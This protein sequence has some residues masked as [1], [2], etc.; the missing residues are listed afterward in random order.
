VTRRPVR[1]SDWAALLDAVFRADAND[2][3]TWLEWKSTLDLRSKEQMATIVA[4]AII[5]MANR[6]PDRAATTVGGIGILLIGMEPGAVHSVAQVDNADLDKL[7]SPY[8]GADGPVW[9]PHWTQYDDRQVLIIEVTPPRWGD[10]IHAFRKEFQPTRDPAAQAAGRGRTVQPITNGAIFVR[11]LAQSVPA[12]HMEIT[13]L[14]NR[15]A[16]GAQDQGIEVSVTIDSPYPL[17]RYRW[18]EDEFARFLAAEAED[19]MGPLEAGRSRRSAHRPGTDFLAKVAAMGG[20][21]P[22]VRAGLTA[23]HLAGLVETIP[24]QRSEAEYEVS[25]RD[26]LDAIRAA[27]PEAMRAAAAYF[28]R[29][30]TFILVNQSTRN[31]Q[32]VLVRL[33]VA[34]DADA[35]E[36]ESDTSGLD[37]WKL[38]PRGPRKWGPRRRELGS[39]EVPRWYTQPI[40]AYGGST[41]PSITVERGGSFTVNFLPVNL[42][43][44][45]R[46]VLADD[47]SV[48]IPAS[49]TEPV[50]ATWTATA[51]NADGPPAEGTFVLRFDGDEINILA[52]VLHAGAQDEGSEG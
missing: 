37:L 19:L 21:S 1:I 24:E 16:S 32:E 9:Q 11:K 3:Q 26:H 45:Q 47:W 18:S 34:G 28:V 46:H 43:P 12:D 14:A 35:R 4:K 17:S 8:V 13:R 42:R 38:L 40:P 6:D 31:Y 44:Q 20:V 29:P 50:T 41:A 5:A 39:I 49:R 23:A 33:H 15:R 51:T 27:W 7:V 10:P 48:L 36:Y 22:N 30:P 52:E 2:E 25:V